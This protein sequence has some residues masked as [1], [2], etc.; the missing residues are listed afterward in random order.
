M[1]IRIFKCTQSKSKTSEKAEAHA[2]K[3]S[4]SAEPTAHDSFPRLCLSD[5]PA[6]DLFISALH[7]LYIHIL[8]FMKVSNCGPLAEESNN[9]SQMSYAWTL[10]FTEGSK[11]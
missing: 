5:G 1:D 10:E 8:D 11:E 6:F 3:G 9:S 7:E 4:R 2:D